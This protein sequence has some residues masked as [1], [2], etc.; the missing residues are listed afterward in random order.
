MYKT[1]YIPVDNSDHSN[2]AVDLGVKLAQEFVSK[3][4]AATSMPPKCTINGSSKWKRGS[5]KNITTKKSS[6]VNARF[7][8][9]SSRAGSRSLPIPTSTTWI[10]SVPSRISPGT[11]VPG[12]SQLEGVGRRHQ[13]QCLR[14]DHYGLAGGGCREGLRHRQQYR[15]GPAP[16]AQFGYVYREGPEAHERGEN[17]RGRGRQPVQLRRPENRACHGESL[18]QAGRGHFRL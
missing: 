4:S 17:R 9:P 3:S 18:E 13:Y 8:I 1:I 12:R 11:T 15:T 2:V 6:T 7:T 14:P 10:K 5:R 16:G